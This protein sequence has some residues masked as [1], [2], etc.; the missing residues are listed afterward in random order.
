M[1]KAL[2]RVTDCTRGTIR[3]TIKMGNRYQFALIALE[4]PGGA[5]ELALAVIII[6]TGRTSNCRTALLKHLGWR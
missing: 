1:V 3:G 4:T 2:L 6:G 5:V